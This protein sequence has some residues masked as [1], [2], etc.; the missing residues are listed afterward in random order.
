MDGTNWY[1]HNARLLL[2]G[3]YAADKANLFSLLDDYANAV[4][5]GDVEL[6]MLLR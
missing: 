5:R 4:R 6:P 1:V 3:Y 2:H